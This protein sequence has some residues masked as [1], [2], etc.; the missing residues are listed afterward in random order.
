MV[1][2][3][4]AHELGFA[5]IRHLTQDL[6]ASELTELLAYFSLF[7]FGDERAD[8]RVGY[9]VCL[10]TNIQRTS[11]KQKTW[12]AFHFIPEYFKLAKKAYATS[13]QD[14]DVGMTDDEML[15]EAE[16]FV[17]EFSRATAK[18]IVRK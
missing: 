4:I 10:Q 9:A 17:G 13:G 15:E 6:S 1:L 11:N 14:E 2:W 7:P 18:G 16:R 8:L 5:S 12:N 3:R